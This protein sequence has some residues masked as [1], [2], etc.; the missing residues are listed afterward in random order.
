M[1][2]KNEKTLEVT[3]E[4]HKAEVE[5]T[6]EVPEDELKNKIA[7]EYG[8]DPESDAELFEKILLKEKSYRQKLSGAIKQKIK[9]REMAKNSTAQPVKKEEQA[10]SPN[11]A[12]LVSK[13]VNDILEKRDLESLDYPDDIKQEIKD[14]AKFKGISVKEAAK[15]EYI[16]LRLEKVAREARIYGA[17]PK[18]SAGGRTTVD[19]SQPLD[20]A[21]FDLNTPEGIKAWREAKAAKATVRK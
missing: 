10:G 9:Y 17:S 12:E 8:I 14:Y 20:P 13:E 16:T 3:P 6:V 4:E 15:S 21:N 11:V 18:R 5:S 19:P 7:E 2:E 1:D